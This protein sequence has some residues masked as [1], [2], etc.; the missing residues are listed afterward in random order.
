MTNCVQQN[1]MFIRSS[2]LTYNNL[3]QL[4]HGFFQNSTVIS[5]VYFFVGHPVPL[6]ILLQ[7]RNKWKL[8]EQN[9]QIIPI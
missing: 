8:L 6:F 5:K 9:Q 7:Y 2:E 4:C 1:V 3:D